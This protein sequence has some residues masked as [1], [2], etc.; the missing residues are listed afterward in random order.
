MFEVDIGISRGD[1]RF[2]C[3]TLWI[4]V[5]LVCFFMFIL[6]IGI[7]GADSQY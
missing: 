2:K 5:F 3:K 4:S 7:S 6:D 1:S